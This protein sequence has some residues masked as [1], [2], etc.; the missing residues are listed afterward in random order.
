MVKFSILQVRLQAADTYYSV[1][2]VIQD[3]IS[4][5]F[6]GLFLIFCPRNRFEDTLQ[7]LIQNYETYQK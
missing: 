3:D 1:L 6:V 2:L 7:P 4:S 5:G